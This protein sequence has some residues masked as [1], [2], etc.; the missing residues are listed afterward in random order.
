VVFED[1]RFTLRELNERVNGLANGLMTLGVAK[2]DKV[3][4]LSL[5]CSQYIEYYFA[6]AKIGA[7]SVP[8][9]FMLQ[10]SDLQ[11]AME[12][13]GSKALIFSEDFKE[14]VV[15]FR[16]GLKGIQTFVYVGKNT[17]EGTANYEAL[18]DR[19]PKNEPKVDVGQQDIFSILYTAGTTGEPKGAVRKHCHVLAGHK[20]YHD[21]GTF[22]RHRPGEP[23]V[24]NLVVPPMFHI[25]GGE[26]ML[27]TITAGGCLVPMKRF[28]PARVLE[29][30]EKEKIT[31]V[32]FV[33]A[34]TFALMNHP[35]FNK[36]DL[37]SL[38]TYLSA[39][40]PLPIEIKK[41]LLKRLPHVLLNDGYG[42]TETGTLTMLP[43]SE[44]EKKMGSVGTPVANME[45]KVIDDNW[46]AVPVNVVGEVACRSPQTSEEYYKNP[47]MTKETIKNGWFRTGDL[48]KFDEDGFLYLVD[49]K[50]DMI[51]TGGENV[52]ALE[53]ENVLYTHP[54]IGEVAVIGLPHSYW[55]EQVTAVVIPKEEPGPTEEEIIA[56]C[57]KNLGG[58]K[59]PK[60][61]I[62]SKEPFPRTPFGKILKKDMRAK[63]G[64]KDYPTLPMKNL[65]GLLKTTKK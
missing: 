17:P 42:L 35:D 46:S 41:E 10:P 53:V 39:S 4:I 47:S 60:Q 22:T 43:H 8:L 34:M 31:S 36:R 55:G 13:A 38:K 32:F 11:S 14:P 58:Y 26:A 52:Y 25:A 2:G 65:F 57:K 29:T 21:L 16:T 15:S 49:R 37:S 63:Y 24:A 27:A 62:I 33:P 30:I 64:K 12:H 7:I 28:D 44:M 56:H 61:V 48:G 6:V 1:K 50:K 19:S 54:G 23:Q 18:A 45:I 9:N 40:A 20:T 59:C 3:S 51:I 5:N